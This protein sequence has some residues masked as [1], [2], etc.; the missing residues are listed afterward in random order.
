MSKL[1]TNYTKETIDGTNK[2]L[3]R[4]KGTF[5]TSGIGIIGN[6]YFTWSG[7]SAADCITSGNTWRSAQDKAEETGA[8]NDHLIAKAKMGLFHAALQGIAIQANTQH[9]GNEVAL[10]STGL[11]MALQGE[12]VGEMEQAVINSIEHVAGVA[13]RAEMNIKKTKLFNHGTNI[14]VK[15]MATNVVV[16]SHSTDKHIIILDGF[17]RAVEYMVRVCYDGTDKTKVWSEWFPY[18]GQ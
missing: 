16:S 1:R 10:K 8:P 6:T 18:L 4:I 14:E 13:G 7:T 11:T 12:E 5:G 15:N 17:T 3:I 9:T 2:I